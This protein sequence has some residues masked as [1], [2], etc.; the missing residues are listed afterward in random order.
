MRALRALLP[1]A[2]ATAAIAQQTLVV[3]A[4]GGQYIWIP[5]PTNCGFFF[6][7]TINTAVTF[8]GVSFP[9]LTPIGQAVGMQMWVTNP[10]TT[11]HVGNEGNQALWSLAASG[12]TAIPEQPGA[13]AV[14][15]TAGATLQPGTYGIALIAQNTQNLFSYNNGLPHTVSNTEMTATLGSTVYGGFA[16]GGL[17]NYVF[18]GTLHYAIGAAPHS[19][20]TK[21]ASGSGCNAVSGSFYQHFTTVGAAATALNGRKLTLLF[22]GPSYTVTQGTVSYIPPTAAATA[23]PTNTNGETTVTLPTPFFYPGGSTT[24]LVVATD[25]HVAPATNIPFTG[26]PS[27][28]PYVPAFLSTLNPIWA[29]CWHNF[30]TAEIGSGTIK[31]EQVGQLFVITWENVENWPGVVGTGQTIN[32]STFQVQFDLSSFDVHYVWQSMTTIGGSQYY[33]QTIVGWSPGGPSPD[34]GAIDVTTLTALPLSPVEVM[35]L[36]LVASAAPVL[37]A[38][39]DLVTSNESSSGVGINFL[40]L[41]ALPAPGLSLAPFGAP[42]CWALVDLSTAAGNVISNLGTPL[43]SMTLQLP[44]PLTPTLSGVVLASQSAWLDAAANP[45]GLTTSNAVTLTLGLFAL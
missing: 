27:Y 4:S 39:V 38:T 32:P 31:T 8:Q 44:I 9:T 14:C 26:T 42:G 5:P 45:F 3:P 13:P 19:C 20:A 34:T 21:V 1:L 28:S 36:T 22:A 43:P 12:T 29:V 25:G 40:S 30:N 16:A 18:N 23:L 33:D 37:G 41:A 17:V 15:F 2:M 24:Q 10:G 35:P 7:L 6:D 11:T